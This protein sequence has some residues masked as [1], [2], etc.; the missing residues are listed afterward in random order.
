[1]FLRNQKTY[2]VISVVA[3][4]SFAVQAYL[5]GPWYVVGGLLAGLIA[6]N[7]VVSVYIHRGLSHGFY[8]FS[9]FWHTALTTITSM[10]NF[11]SAA[12]AAG[13][14][15]THHKY[16]DTTKDP[17]NVHNIG[18]LRF[19]LKDWGPAYRPNQRLMAKLLKVPEIK[20]QHERHLGV[21]AAFALLAPFFAVSGYWLINLHYLLIHLGSDK[22]D[23]SQNAWWL[24]PL[25]WGEEF[26][27]KHH[28]NPSAK[29]L[30]RF[31]LIHFLGQAFSVSAGSSAKTQR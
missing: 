6:Y 21:S 20:R 2:A 11:G 29:K 13:V 7:L 16:A 18:L 19:L 5:L 4:I 24:F 30:H 15:I 27:R 23:T 14:H 22:T 3:H 9:S 1:M 26:H 17:H 25:M 10:L 8:S 31:D 28:H 12:V